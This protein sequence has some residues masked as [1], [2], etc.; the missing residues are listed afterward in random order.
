[1]TNFRYRIP[2]EINILFYSN[3]NEYVIFWSNFITNLSK[4]N[5]AIRFYIDEDLESEYF[6]ICNQLKEKYPYNP[7]PIALLM[8]LRLVND[9]IRLCS[10][11][12]IIKYFKEE[13][14]R[15]ELAISKY[16][17]TEKYFG[18]DLLF[19]RKGSLFE[20]IGKKPFKDKI[21]PKLHNAGYSIFLNFKRYYKQEITN[22]HTKTRENNFLVNS[23]S[24][25]LFE[26]N[27]NLLKLSDYL[28]ENFNPS[29]GR[30]KP[31]TK[32]N[33]IYFLLRN[34]TEEFNQRNYIVFVQEC[35]CKNYSPSRI[36]GS[37]ANHQKTLKNLQLLFEK[38]NGIKL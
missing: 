17:S 2:D 21:N 10:N 15:L 3:K 30:V 27:Q 12:N 19:F 37:N 4:Q 26:G 24:I 28:N 25:S 14:Q 8:D 35:Y 22:T 20:E 5:D 16:D 18:I 36:N 23:K 38:D 11:S 29:D 33:Q 32:Y 7:S 6:N 13:K 31:T 34:Y 1:M 9:N